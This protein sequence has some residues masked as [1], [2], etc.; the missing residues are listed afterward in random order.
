L[1]SSDLSL[2]KTSERLLPL[3]KEI[4]FYLELD[5][6]IQAKENIVQKRRKKI[7]GFI[8]DETLLKVNNQFVWVWIAIDSIDKIILGIRISFERTILIAERFIK[9]LVK[10]YG[11]H[12]V[13]TD[14]G[15]WYPQQYK[16]LKLEHHLYSL[17]EK[18]IM[19]R[20]MQ[21]LKDRTE[22]LDDYFPCRK[23]NCNLQHVMQW[24]ILFIDMHNRMILEKAIK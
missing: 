15:T 14:G 1:Y 12:P 21:Y 17:Y 18:N 16:F 22:G 8:V 4:I 3:S 24:L 7:E 19:E 2:R 11:K 20:T 5:S 23:Y 13:S 9:N 10:R 6:G